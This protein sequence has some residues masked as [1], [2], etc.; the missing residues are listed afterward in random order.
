MAAKTVPGVLAS[1]A[2]VD[3]AVE[4]ISGLMAR[5]FRDLTV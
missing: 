3:A 4:A 1:F 2:H 5:G